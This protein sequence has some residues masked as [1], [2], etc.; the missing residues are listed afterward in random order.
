MAYLEEFSN[1]IAARDYM[2][3]MELWQEYCESDE[4]DADE[5]Q[6]ILSLLKQS[7]VQQRFG[8]IIEQILPLVMTI[9]DEKRKLFCIASLFDIQTTQ[10]Q[11]LWDIAH[12]VIKTHFGTD[13]QF[14]EKLRLVG[15][16]TK[17]NFQGA[18]SNFILLNHIKKGN[19]VL[20]DAGWGVG[21]IIDCSFLREQVTVEF[22]NLGGTKRDIPFKNAYKSL[23]P[24]PSDHV[25]SLR[26]AH[27]EILGKM[28]LH[29]SVGLVIKILTDLGPKNAQDIKELLS[30]TIIDEGSYSK[31]WQNTRNK[32][33]KDSRIEIPEESPKAPYAVRKGL[34]TLDE[35]I[36]K[37]LHNKRTFQDKLSA[38]H[39]LVRDFPQLLKEDTTRNELFK[40]TENLLETENLSLIQTLLVYFLMGDID[41]E[42]AQKYTSLITSSIMKLDSYEEALQAIE[43]VSLKKRLLIALRNGHPDWKII[44]S[45]LL[46]NAEPLQ[47][48]D[49]IMKELL[50]AADG[51]KLVLER[52]EFLLDHPVR[53]PEAF[54]WYFQKVSDRGGKTNTSSSVPFFGDQR[55]LERFFES[56]LLLYAAIEFRQD[57]KDLVKK[58]YAI[59][60]GDRYKLVRDM[61]KESD[62]AYA[63]EFLLLTSKCRSL[64]D[65]DQKILRSL[66]SVVHTSLSEPNDDE[67]SAHL[68]IL[69]ATEESYQKIKEKIHH[70]G[71]VEIVENAREIEEARKLG[72]LRENS[73]Y[74]FALER[75]ARLQKDLKTLSDQFQK[76]RII[77]PDDIST[78]TIGIGTKVDLQTEAGDRI[79]YTILGPWDADSE[80]NILAIESKIAQSMVGKKLRDHVDLKGEKATILQIQSIFDSNK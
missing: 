76:A 26:Y 80:A 32:L 35:R 63:R 55:S 52:L 41:E 79:S 72:D 25:L 53:Y 17:G 6:G 7:E 75:R 64:T 24:L 51:K 71:T 36:E 21:E 62:I 19:F 33:K 27:P 1:S 44:F 16:R 29:E 50:Q 37:A 66:V 59:L 42:K 61:L 67:D 70:I 38:I 14:Q 31:W 13:P 4:A 30:G 9:P 65:H 10:S 47:L 49:Y 57:M 56:F 54:L 3:V 78:E 28:A 11:A 48:K 77:T 45:Q 5:I 22:E 23:K 34:I 20:H 73:E 43:I 15:L 2:K 60:T 46:L 69:W 40:K 18:I 58:M 8:T 12:E 68:Q 74:K 39:S